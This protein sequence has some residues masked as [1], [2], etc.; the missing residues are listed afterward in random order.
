MTRVQFVNDEIK[1]KSEQL[2]S[3]NSTSLEKDIKRFTKIKEDFNKMVE[4]KVKET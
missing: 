1:I 4:E 3:L 2:K